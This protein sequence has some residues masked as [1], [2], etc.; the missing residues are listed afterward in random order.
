MW[1]HFWF[2][3][4]FF[5]LIAT[6]ANQ[7]ICLKIVQIITNCF[8]FVFHLSGIPINQ[9][10][11]AWVAVFLLPVNSALNPVLYTL[12][13]KM[14]KQQMNRMFAHRFSSRY[15][16]HQASTV[17]GENSNSSFCSI[18]QRDISNANNHTVT[19]VGGNGVYSSKF[20][21]QNSLYLFNR[22]FPSF[23]FFTRV[24]QFAVKLILYNNYFLFFFRNDLQN[25]TNHQ[26]NP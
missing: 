13:T 3:L 14:F 21:S 17:V 5:K 20:S 19:T 6:S 16:C 22:R 4:Y 7:Q 18:S 24:C 9:D 23:P 12:T 10:L 26:W 15:R 1:Q 8:W 2:V 25:Q 11:Y